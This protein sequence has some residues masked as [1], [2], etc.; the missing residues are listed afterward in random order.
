MPDFVGR[1]HAAMRKSG[2]KRELILDGERML[3]P[4]SVGLLVV[5]ALLAASVALHWLVLRGDPDGIRSGSRSTANGNAAEQIVAA[6]AG[7]NFRR[8]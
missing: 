5:S 1:H 8:A 6:K 3:L 4:F 7:M 2:H